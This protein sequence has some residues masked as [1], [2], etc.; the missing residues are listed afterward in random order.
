MTDQDKIDARGLSCPQPALMTKQAL[1]AAGGG[2]I[3]V[4]VDTKTQVQNCIRTA[5]KLKWQASYEERE[6]TFEI[7]LH[8]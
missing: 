7:T 1:T 3:I 2:E 4:Q 8:K 6:G 5:E